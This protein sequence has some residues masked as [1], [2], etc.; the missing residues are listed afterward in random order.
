MTDTTTNICGFYNI[1]TNAYFFIITIATK[2][3]VFDVEFSLEFTIFCQEFSLFA[4]LFRLGRNVRGDE[5]NSCCILVHIELVAQHLQVCM[6]IT[7]F[8]ISGIH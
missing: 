1:L 6:L 2:W 4:I 7:T 3:L 5:N 8:M